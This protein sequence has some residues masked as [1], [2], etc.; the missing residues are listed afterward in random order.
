[1]IVKIWILIF[2]I[3]TTTRWLPVLVTTYETAQCHNPEG[4]NA[5]TLL[6]ELLMVSGGKADRRM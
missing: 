3:V 1:M 2:W 6:A 4:H 5:H